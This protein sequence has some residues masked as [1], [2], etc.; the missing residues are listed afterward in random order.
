[1][2]VVYVLIAVIVSGFL[3]TQTGSLER[4]ATY[5]S[6][7]QCELQANVLKE[8][9]KVTRQFVYTVCLSEDARQTAK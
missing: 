1:M 2:N 5:Q 3:P 6:K 7:E 9:L 4:I 8:Q